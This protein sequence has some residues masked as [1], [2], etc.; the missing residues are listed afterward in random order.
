ME[1][2]KVPEERANN[3]PHEMGWFDRL[4]AE[5]GERVR[6]GEVPPGK[7]IVED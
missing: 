1:A 2:Y 4:N 5:D 3:R 7:I 6:L